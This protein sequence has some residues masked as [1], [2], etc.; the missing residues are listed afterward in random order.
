MPSGSI[1]ALSRAIRCG[2][3][4]SFTSKIHTRCADQGLP[5]GFVLTSGEVS[6]HTG[7]RAVD[8]MP[9]TTPKGLSADKGYDGDR[10]RD[11]LLMRGILPII[12]S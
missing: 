4:G 1:S 10:F 12:R 6:K 8:W 7:C 5:V 2:V 9:L 3:N 11:S